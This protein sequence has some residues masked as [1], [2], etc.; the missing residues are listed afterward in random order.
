MKILAND[1]LAQNAIDK[2]QKAGHHVFNSHVEQQ[3]LANYIREEKIDVLLVRSA[4]QVRKEL[5]DQCADLKMIGRGGVGMD[6]IDVEY[7]R[8]L[9]KTVFNTPA[10]S[11]QAVAELV[12][13][14]LF[15]M[16]RTLYDANRR[17]P[18]EGQDKFKDLKKQYGGGIELRDKTLGIIGFGRIGQYLAK[19]AL[20]NGMKV[21][22]YDMRPIEADIPIEINGVQVHVEKIKTCDLQEVL[23]ASDMIS[24]HVPKQADGSAVIGASEMDLMKTGVML[25]NTARGGSIDESALKQ[26]LNSGK[27]ACAALDVFENEP[28]PDVELLVHQKLSLSPHIGAATVEA[29]ARI[30]LEIADIII[31]A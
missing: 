7:A 11:S 27:I 14:H 26:A 10:S 24:L 28:N 22:A 18:S 1:G 17:M 19:Y 15:S 8:S 30:G 2:L 23:K 3:K 6:N 12:M 29:Q 9:G 25:V 20:G 16:A 5:L 31:S 21:L 13:A 4:T